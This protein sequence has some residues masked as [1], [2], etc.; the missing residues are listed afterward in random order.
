MPRSTENLITIP[1]YEPESTVISRF[2]DECVVAL[3]DQ[4][5]IDYGNENIKK[6]VN[7]HISNNFETFDDNVKD[8]LLL[9][10]NW[11]NEWP[12]SRS[13][14]LGTNLLDTEF[15]IDSLSDSTIYMAYY[16][17][18]HIIEKIPKDLIN[19]DFYDYIFM[20]T[21]LP[22]HIIDNNIINLMNDMKREFNYWYPMDL[23]VSGKD[24]IQNHLTMC[25]Y[26]HAM[27]FPNYMPSSYYVNGHILLNN[28]KMSKSEGI[29]MTINEAINK[30]GADVTRFVLAE[31]SPNG[32][33]DGNFMEDICER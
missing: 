23:R 30:Y 27:I 15:V 11:I 22:S 13:F 1:Y 12:C 25:L 33:S 31:S 26:N 3:A 19:D 9:G 29:F 7:E 17:I 14:G 10:S 32:I 28:K 8:Q 20:D 24:L 21:K 18:S 6:I 5:Y 16:T 4:W 2:G